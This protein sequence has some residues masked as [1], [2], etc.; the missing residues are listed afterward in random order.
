[1]FQHSDPKQIFASELPELRKHAGFRRDVA[2]ALA[3][4]RATHPNEVYRALIAGGDVP[5]DVWDEIGD[6]V[7]G[8]FESHARPVLT[9]EW[10]GRAPMGGDG[11]TQVLALRGVHVCVS[12]DWESD[13]PYGSVDVAATCYESFAQPTNFADLSSKRLSMR[14]LCGLVADL[15]LPIEDLDGFTVNG[16]E[17]RRNDDGRIVPVRR[18]PAPR[19]PAPAAAPSAPSAS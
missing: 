17:V 18:R 11:C 8:A 3:T 14:E 9:L 5:D 7:V 4:I 2:D 10:D 13:G 19:A 16:R 15:D 6:A 12:T 1:M